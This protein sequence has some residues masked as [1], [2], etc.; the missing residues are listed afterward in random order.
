MSDIN[1]LARKARHTAFE[2]SCSHLDAGRKEKLVKAYKTQDARRE[3][4]ISGF[5]ER[6]AKVKK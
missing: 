4:N 2:A 5:R 1:Q 6:V 3:K